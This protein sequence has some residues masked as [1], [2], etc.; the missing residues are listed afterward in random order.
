V[1][2][3]LVDAQIV[4]M[5]VF[6]VAVHCYHHG[7]E[8]IRNSLDGS[9]GMA[10]RIASLL[11]GILSSVFG[12][13]VYAQPDTFTSLGEGIVYTEGCDFDDGAVFVVLGQSIDAKNGGLRIWALVI[14]SFGLFDII[15]MSSA[16]FLPRRVT[17]F[18]GIRDQPT[19][20][21]PR[22]ITAT[23]LA[24]MI[25]LIITT[26]Q[27]ISRSNL[28]TVA[29]EWTLGQTISLLKVLDQLM[30]SISRIRKKG[31]DRAR[32]QLYETQIRQLGLHL[33]DPEEC[34]DGLTIVHS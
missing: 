19:Q 2:L 16:A 7:E 9:F 15:R 14:F 4:T 27:I 13:V 8:L 31:I 20:R 11:H 26:E 21:Q 28:Q 3:T 32:W 33:E 12:I 10:Y 23:G 5:L 24:V 6:I 18:L 30:K 1:G 22:R 29:N 25:Y 17:H 34:N